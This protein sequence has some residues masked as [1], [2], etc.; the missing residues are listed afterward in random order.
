MDR[1]KKIVGETVVVERENILLFHITSPCAKSLNILSRHM[2]TLVGGHFAQT[3]YF[4]LKFL[5]IDWPLRDLVGETKA[6]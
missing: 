1:T 3:Y 6:F 2:F 4:C 5:F